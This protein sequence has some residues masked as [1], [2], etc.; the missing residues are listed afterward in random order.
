MMYQTFKTEC[1]RLESLGYAISNR[2]NHN[3]TATAKK[4][5]RVLQI[6]VK[7]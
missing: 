5:R 1:E 4:G 7:K 6:G 2:D 3:C